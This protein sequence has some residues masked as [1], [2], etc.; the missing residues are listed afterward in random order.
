[1]KNLNKISDNGKLV[2]TLSILAIMALGLYFSLAF[3]GIDLK[4]MLDTTFNFNPS[5][6]HSVLGGYDVTLRGHYMIAEIIDFVTMIF[7]SLVQ[8]IVVM[9]AFNTISWG[10]K[11][12]IIPIAAMALNSLKVIAIITILLQFPNESIALANLAN[13]VNM[14]KTIFVDGSLGLVL[15]SAI[16]LLGRGIR[17]VFLT[18]K[19][20]S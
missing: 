4:T 14:A 5:Q 10:G 15:V 17:K 20:T 18:K 8:A 2:A 7:V 3:K 13:V 6:V 12:Y 1:M 11:L 9:R 19:I 16:I